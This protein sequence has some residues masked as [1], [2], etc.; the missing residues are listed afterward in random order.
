MGYL[1]IKRNKRL[2]KL[3][4]IHEREGGV[5]IIFLIHLSTMKNPGHCINKDK[6]A[7]KNGKKAD[8]LGTSGF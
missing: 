1:S 3:N 4:E 6:K 7:Q 8:C 5:D 2:K